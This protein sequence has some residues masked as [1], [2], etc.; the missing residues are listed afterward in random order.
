MNDPHVTAL[1]YWVEHDESVDYD[2][3][4][5]LEY[6]N[7]LFRVCINNRQVTIR[8]KVHYASEE[9]ARE[10]VEIFIRNWEFDAALNLGGSKF[11]LRYSAAD[12]SDRNPTPS[13]PGVVQLSV[14]PIRLGHLQFSVQ[15]LRIRTESYPS[16][17]LGPML[18]VD[19]QFVQAMLS[20]LERFQK[21][22]EPLASMA[23]FCLTTLR[24]NTPKGEGKASNDNQVRGYYAISRQVLKQVS[25]LSSERGGSEARKGG[26]LGKDFTNEEKRF[27]VAAVRAFIRRAAEKETNPGHCLAEITLADLPTVPKPR[28]QHQEQDASHQVR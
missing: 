27:L 12:I 28:E 17:P 16:P 21:G 2:D 24:N 20:R 3:A 11:S 22:R 8:P 1:H 7:E 5:P 23:Y 6:E 13:P 4:R 10:A 18:E 25:R 14:A 19:T 9:E 15:R 26:G